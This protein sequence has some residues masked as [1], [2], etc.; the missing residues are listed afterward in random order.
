[1]DNLED[2]P[3]SFRKKMIELQK[4]MLLKSASREVKREKRDPREIVLSILEDDRAREIL[5]LA[6][7]QYPV[8]TKIVIHRI[9]QLVEKGKIDRLDAYTLYSIFSYLG[10]PVRVPTRITF[11]KKGRKL[12]LK[13]V[14][15]D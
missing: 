12:S 7:A 8:E 5:E 14:L 11:V 9:A 10:I 15:E 3:L 6:E 1:M 4:K 13:E 2:L